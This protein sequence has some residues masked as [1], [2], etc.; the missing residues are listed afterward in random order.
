MFDYRKLRGRIREQLGNEKTFAQELG[1]STNSLSMKLNGKIG[2]VQQEIDKSIKVL[3][4]PDEEISAYF[5]TTK[6]Q[7][8]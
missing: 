7:Q 3:Q 6:V 8:S 2:F 1:I 5:F 4:I